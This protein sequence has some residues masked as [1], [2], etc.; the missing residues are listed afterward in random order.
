MGASP[1][2]GGD[3]QTDAVDERPQRAPLREVA[4]AVV[5]NQEH[6]LAGV[7][8]VRLGDAETQQ[9]S[10]DEARMLVEYLP[11]RRLHAGLRRRLGA[12]RHTR[13]GPRTH[14]R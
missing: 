5:E 1:E 2:I 13:Q 11:E 12:V 4:E 9:R 6:L 14:I 10:P 3:A 7:G 8:H